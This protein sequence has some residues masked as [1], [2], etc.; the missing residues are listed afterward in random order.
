MKAEISHESKLVAHALHSELARDRV[1]IDRG[2]M[3]YVIFSEP[4]CVHCGCTTF[5][6]CVGPMGAADTCYWVA[7]EDDTNRGL[8]SACS[9]KGVKFKFSRKGVLM[10]KKIKSK[11]TKKRPASKPKQ[12]PLEQGG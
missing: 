3:A 11:P 12:T 7:S 4:T 8:C 5:N 1:M 6:P 9:F 2:G 10:A